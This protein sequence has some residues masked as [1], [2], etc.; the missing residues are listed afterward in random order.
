[1]SWFVAPLYDLLMRRTEAACLRPWRAEI[2]MSARGRVLEIGAGTGANLGLY[3]EAVEALTLLEPDGGMRRQLH[4]KLKQHQSHSPEIVDASAEALPFD[5]ASF[6]TVVS[7]LVL[8]TVPEPLTALGELYRVLRRGGAL[9]YLEHVHAADNPS[10]A[11]WQRRFNPLWRSLM[12]GCELTRDTA[13][14]MEQAG[15]T[16][17]TCVRESMRKALPLVRPTIRGLARRD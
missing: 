7:T 5:D 8:C 17:E 16:V 4:K 2:L 3:P 6:D 14:A 12:G 13:T 15:F 11:R 9:L 1:M 10:R